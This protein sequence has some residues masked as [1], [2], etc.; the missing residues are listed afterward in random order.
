MENTEGTQVKKQKKGLSG[1]IKSLVSRII[2]VF[3]D[4]PVT[5]IAIM[6]A[7]L[8]FSLIV[9]D[10]G[11][12]TDKFLTKFA[13][14]CLITATGSLFFEELFK[15]KF[16]VRIAGYCLSAI[17]AIIYVTIFFTEK[18]ML[19]GME[20]DVVSETA[21]K[22][23]ALQGVILLGF[24]VWHMF[25]RLEDDFEVYATKAFVELIKATVIYGL[26]AAGLAV[27]VLIFDALI[28]KT[29]DFLSQVEIFL[30][31]GIYVPMCLKAISGKNEAPEKFFRVCIQYVLLPMLLISFAIIYLYIAKVFITNDVPSNRIF[32]ILAGLFAIGLPVWTCVHGLQQKE[33]FLPKAAAFLPYVFL[34]FV[35]LQCWSIGL[36]IGQYG[37][38]E[39]RYFAITLILCEIIYFVLYVLHH[40]GNKQAISWV[41]FA[42]MGVTF[43]SLLCPGTTYEDVT[44]RSQM[45][46]MKK[47]LASSA[48]T[49]EEKSS[50][51]NCYREIKGVGFKGKKALETQL[52]QEQKDVIDTYDEYGSLIHDRIY[53]HSYKSS[54]YIEVAGY[55]RL[56]EINTSSDKS[57]YLGDG[58]LKVQ[59]AN[60]E[61]RNNSEPILA[62]V[63]ELVDYALTFT[64]SYDNNFSIDD[65]RVCPVNDHQAIWV[66]NFTIS[67]YKDTNKIETIYLNGYLMEK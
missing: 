41:L 38:T 55:S 13:N 34:P 20:A 58:K 46:R 2:D 50:I 17:S 14:V 10:L 37:I 30:A 9:G 36:R 61:K 52:T 11:K 56:Y 42:A 48:P 25:R 29:H 63:S 31:S 57:S 3:R 16:I 45:S 12:E 49:D 60:Y 51:K 22:L 32:Y 8:G 1:I 39:P 64:K 35:L 24:A 26:F 19:L 66:T 21:A 6:L 40:K 33:G 5:M 7:A 27:I 18:E 65:Y 28:F 43:F 15:K 62:D 59:Y 67:F 23:L 53:L 44:V 4:Y 47:M 54:D